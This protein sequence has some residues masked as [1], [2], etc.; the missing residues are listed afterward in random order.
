ME[1]I[2]GNLLKSLPKIENFIYLNEPKE[3]GLVKVELS[4]WEVYKGGLNMVL[5][6]VIINIESDQ[7]LG[8]FVSHLKTIKHI[9]DNLLDRISFDDWGN[10]IKPNN[11]SV[12][13]SGGSL[14]HSCEFDGEMLTL[15]IG[16]MFSGEY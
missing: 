10:L 6:N 3:I 13:Y 15:D 4:D 9:M 8:G 16:F 14:V 5:I 11:K 2:K 12:S 7:D 1:D